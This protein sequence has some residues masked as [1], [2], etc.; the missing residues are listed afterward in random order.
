MPTGHLN[1]RFPFW[2]P[3]DKGSILNTDN[4]LGHIPW[5]SH[6]TGFLPLEEGVSIIIIIIF[7]SE[8][9]NSMST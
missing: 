5:L 6:N 3:G 9:F 8:H 7:R 2:E 4:D 1:N